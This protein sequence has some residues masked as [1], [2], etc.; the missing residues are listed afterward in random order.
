MLIKN[1][2]DCKPITAGD[3]AVL[4]EILHSKNDKVN[5]GFSFSYAKVLPGETS[6][7]HALDQT[8]VY[9]ILKGTGRMTIDTESADIKEKDA[10]YIPPQKVQYIRN[11]NEKE[12][13]EFLCIVCPE[14]SIG[15]EKVI[16]W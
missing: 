16:P 11:T 2:D 3:R 15:K 12:T 5:L 1:L 4:K 14:W 10:I 13:L 9:Y 7:P 6:L 8:E